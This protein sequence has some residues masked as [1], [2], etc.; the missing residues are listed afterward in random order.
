MAGIGENQA[1]VCQDHFN[2]VVHFN[3]PFPVSSSSSFFP[4]AAA[5]SPTC[6]ENIKHVLHI[7][8]RV[9]RHEQVSVSEEDI[10]LSD[11]IFPPIGEALKLSTGRIVAE[12]RDPQR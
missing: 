5:L 2:L 11:A 10:N 9:N 4:S 3:P 6:T 7:D 1:L 8:D 12:Y